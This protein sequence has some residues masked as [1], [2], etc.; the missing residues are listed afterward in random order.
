VDV[1]GR[2]VLDLRPLRESPDWRRL[3][4]GGLLSQIGGQ[5]TTFAVVLQVFTLTRSSIAVGAAGLCAALPAVVFGLLG[6]TFADAVDRR[7]LVL[8]TSTALA[9]VSA[10]FA[11]QAFA[12]LTA[13]WPLYLLLVVQSLL[14]AVNGPARRTFTPRLLPP[15]RLAAGAAVT[16]LCQHAAVTLGPLLAG[17]LAGFGGLRSCYLLD[18]ISFAGALY[19]VF[20][21]PPMPPLGNPGK[22]GLWA[23]GAALGFIGR[24][25]VLLGAFL[26]D[27][28]ATVLGMPLALFP[29]INA[30]HFGGSPQ[31]LGLLA[32]GPSI[33]GILGSLLS[34]PVGRV[35]RQ[36]RAMLL[37][38]VVWGV[39]IAGFGLVTALWAAVAMLA[40]AGAADP[41]LVVF[42]STMVQVITP[43]EYRGRVSAVDYVV[44]ASCPQLG[45]FRAGV[46]AGLTT[47]GISAVIGGLS[48]L[49]GAAV[50][51]LT[52][53]A[54]AEYRSP[55][56]E[57]RVP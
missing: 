27:L 36:G 37:L 14:V 13:V 26:A 38:T 46:L 29:A 28:N 2:W 33:G 35:S 8:G 12:G 47:P 23:I 42:R 20:R 15:E 50:I 24:T 10:L 52:V 48:T 7:K 45:N 21:L 41:L 30:A 56:A 57:S 18:A 16:M 39:G 49:L 34:G 43:D 44:G 6:G 53:P 11:A 32:A 4:L 22:P 54:F 17:L 9:G 19:G 55:H 40:L 5:L 1:A 25:R 3:Q 51:R 31:T